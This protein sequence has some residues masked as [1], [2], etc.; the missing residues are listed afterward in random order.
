LY[1][2]ISVVAAT[3][4]ELGMLVLGAA[5]YVR[6]LVRKRIEVIPV[7]RPFWSR[8]FPEAWLYSLVFFI[9]V[10]ALRTYCML[11]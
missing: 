3:A 7:L 9:V 6:Y 4:L 8:I 5:W 2:S 11:M 10:T 1:N